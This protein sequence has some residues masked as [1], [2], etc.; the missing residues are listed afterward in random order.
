LGQL[1][2]GLTNTQNWNNYKDNEIVVGGTSHHTN[3]GIAN[4][5][6]YQSTF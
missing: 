5:D 6:S 3:D 1:P 2:G 4:S